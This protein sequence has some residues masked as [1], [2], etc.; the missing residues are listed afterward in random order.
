MKLE[1]VYARR[2]DLRA[3]LADRF[4]LKVDVREPN[5]CWEW[6]AGRGHYGKAKLN[7]GAF[8]FFRGLSTTAHRA[9]YLIT[10]GEV[11]DGIFVCHD[12]DNPPCCNPNHLFLGTGKDN[13]ADRDQKGRYVLGDRPKG[14]RN[15]NAKL[16]DSLV[17]EARLRVAGGESLKPIAKE[18]GVSSEALAQAV[19]GHTWTHVPTPTV[20]AAT[21]Y[22]NARKQHSQFMKARYA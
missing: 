8:A 19:K 1:D 18:Y 20:S 22:R 17:A 5:E 3:T 9:A 14:T 4:W 7:Y 13:A 16:D 21:L 11:P 6:Q 10:H 12:C 2:P 15:H